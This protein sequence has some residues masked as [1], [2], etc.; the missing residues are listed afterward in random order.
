ME[1]AEVRYGRTLDDAVSKVLN[2]QTT[3]RQF[4]G[5]A[6]ALGMTTAGILSVLEACSTGSTT[7]SGG[8][9]SLKKYAGAKISVLTDVGETDEKGLQDKISYIKDTY[10][11]TMTVDTLA[12]GPLIAKTTEVLNA[13]SS[14]YDIINVVAIQVPVWVAA[15]KFVR[16][17]EFISDSNRTPAGYDFADFPTPSVLNLNWDKTNQTYSASGEIN[18]IPGIHS[19]SVLA[20]YRKDLLDKAGLQIPKTWDDWM[21]A[22]KAMHNPSAG[23]YGCSVIGANDFSLT[24]VDWWHRFENIGGKLFTGSIKDKSYKPNVNSAEGIKAL[25]ML[26][27]ALKYAS[28][29]VTTFGFPESVDNMA[30]GKTGQ[31]VMW[32]TIAGGIYDPNNSKVADKIV[33]STVPTNLSGQKP[34]SFLGGWGLGIP[35]NSKNIDAAWH[36]MTYITSREFEKYQVLTYQNDPNRKSI[37]Q[38]PDVD[39][40][41]PSEPLG[42]QATEG[43][44]VFEGAYT[45]D[46]VAM[47]TVSNAEFNN[48]LLGN[49]T[50]AQACA[51]VQTAWEGIGKKTG[52]LT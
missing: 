13:D 5:R 23:V 3:R 50:A 10:G 4:I 36:L 29:H 8:G 49:Q 14:P 20:F 47:L 34:I 52:W 35:K 19:G 21:A 37:F 1:E 26:I 51:K 39:K 46:Y 40:L 48:A 45:P 17:N 2:G 6:I 33:A 22:A 44:K 7:S 9:Y 25:Q 16:L 43:G 41:I 28:P 11:I 12:L 24:S 18:L 32:S 42:L 38:D 15:G 27:D 30:A 31:F